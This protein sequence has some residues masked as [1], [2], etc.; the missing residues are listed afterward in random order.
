MSEQTITIRLKKGGMALHQEGL[1][2]SEKGKEVLAY[3]TTVPG[4]FP[5]IMIKDGP[6]KGTWMV[7]STAT[8]MEDLTAL[9]T[10]AK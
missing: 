4:G 8:F 5:Y 3:H 7:V 2:I 1:T 6:N 9:L 10:E